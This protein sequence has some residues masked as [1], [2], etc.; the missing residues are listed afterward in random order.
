MHNNT[1][2]ETKHTV[3]N[4][5]NTGNMERMYTKTRAACYKA[6]VKCQELGIKSVLIQVYLNSLFYKIRCQ[7]F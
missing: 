4:L 7:G 6:R 5:S 1:E 2:T 3:D